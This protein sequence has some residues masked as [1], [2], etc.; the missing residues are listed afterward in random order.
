MELNPL[1]GAVKNGARA[2]A[3]IA[4]ST[5]STQFSPSLSRDVG[6]L[7]ETDVQK[8]LQERQPFR[9]ALA[10]KVRL[11][12]ARADE[13]EALGSLETLR[14][15]VVAFLSFWAQRLRDNSLSPEELGAARWCANRFVNLPVARLHKSQIQASG[16]EAAR[17]PANS[18][19]ATG[20]GEEEFADLSRAV[21]QA[22]R[23]TDL[24]ALAEAGPT[25][26]AT[27]RKTAA[28]H[29]LAIAD[30]EAI[31]AKPSVEY[32][33]SDRDVRLAYV[34]AQGIR[35][36]PAE[37]HLSFERAG[38]P[39]SALI[40]GD[41]GTGK[42]SIVD[43]IEFALQGRIAR[44]ADFNSTLAPSIRNLATGGQAAVEVGLSDSTSVRRSSSIAPEG[45][46]E[47][48][49]ELPRA[50]FRLAPIS[51]KRADIL[52]FLDTDALSRGTVFFD[53]FPDE[54]RSL[55]KRPD[56]E[57]ASMREEQHEL[58]IRRSGLARD[59]AG[60]T[61][62]DPTD[63]ADASK[64]ATLIRSRLLG[65]TSISAAISSGTWSRLD[66]D[67][68]ETILE[69]RDVH[70]RLRHVKR[71]LA[72]GAEVLNPRWHE[73]RAARLRPILSSV[74]FDLTDSFLAVTRAPHV[75]RLRVLVG[76]SGPVSLDVVVE[77]TN[78]RSAY[79]Q[80]VFSEGWR[81]LVAILFFVSVA[82]QAAAHG[83][84]R[85][86]LLDDVLQSVDA[87]VRLSL[88]NYLLDHFAEWQIVVTL[89]DRLWLEQLRGVFRRHNHP[90]Q[91]CSLRQWTFNDGPVAGSVPSEATGALKAALELGDAGALCALAGRLLEQLCDA[92]SWRLAISVHRTRDDKYT[93]APLWQGVSKE[94]RRTKLAPLVSAIE[95]RVDLRNIA[96]AHYNEWANQLAW[97]E[98]AQFARDILELWDECFCQN[99]WDFVARNDGGSITCQCGQLVVN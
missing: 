96:G 47:T 64:F 73:D 71:A 32:D 51:L 37:F 61:R 90:F 82:R 79:P 15:G 93:L 43:S 19:R 57:L 12:V 28:D 89:H 80:Q 56:E 75:E 6:D 29:L 7:S 4:A 53:Y 13:A 95:D 84:A 36:I 5:L 55:G 62:L 99:C 16:I 39:I 20:L 23:I 67:L 14:Q 38:K 59:L 17:D 48:T 2:L 9:R 70:A 8:Q 10:L 30:D 50:G 18:Q 22:F 74:G 42:S 27:Y 46:I 54:G 78:G 49:G 94:L 77:F 81:D 86:L 98:A 65:G 11:V 1:D 87:G 91:E 69:L 26:S 83:Q 21:A 52:Q 44:S 58:R 88:M 66:A 41:N 35:G 33:A 97:S 85:V 76:E 3:V 31:I 72:R 40:F 60:L 92:L 68:R 34:R 24:E 25:P 63:L 45:R